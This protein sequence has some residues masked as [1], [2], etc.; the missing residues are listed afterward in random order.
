MLTFKAL[1]ILIDYPTEER[2][3]ALPEIV[4]VL[5]A[6]RV[7]RGEPLSAVANLVDH[8]QSRS[9]LATQEEYVQLFDRGRKLSLHIFEHTHGES[10]DRGPAMIALMEQYRSAGL[11]LSAPELPDFLPLVLEF[12]SRQPL[13]EA[14]LLLSECMPVLTLLGARLS[15]RASPYEAVFTALE[16]I[17]GPAEEAQALRRQVAEEGPD[18]ALTNIDKVWEEEAITFEEQSA[19]SGRH[20]AGTTVSGAGGNQ[21]AEPLRWVDASART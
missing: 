10:R 21:A 14:R 3:A 1:S 17:A 7:L 20:T 8:L 9:L 2:R 12:A 5:E 16:A 4:S 19:L 6:E 11:E 18:E 13:E 15:A